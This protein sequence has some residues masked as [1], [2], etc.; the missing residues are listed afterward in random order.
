M[1]S[2]KSKITLSI[3]ICSLLSSLL[4]GL[5]SMSNVRQVSNKGASSEMSLSAENTKMQIDALITRIEQSVDTLSSIFLEQVDLEQMQ[6]SD[7]YVTAL[8][9]S[10]QSI[11]LSF[12]QHTEGTITA[13]IRYNP[14]FTDP[15]SGL[16]LSRNSLSED[17]ISIVPTDFTMYE[18]T[19]LAHVGCYYIPVEN[20]APLWMDPYLN[21][22]INVYMVSYVVPIYIDGVSVG[23]IGM[24]IDFS[25]ICDI[26]D[27]VTVFDSGY[28]FLTSDDGVITHHP[29]LETGTDLSEAYGGIP[30]MKTALAD[31]GKEGEYLEYSCQG[32][33]R[34]FVYYSLENGMKLVV[35]ASLSEIKADADKLSL[36]ILYFIIFSIILS[37]VLGLVISSN[38]ANPLKKMTNII[39]KTSELDFTSSGSVGA[40]LVKRRDETGVMAKAVQAMRKALRELVQD[41]MQTESSIMKNVDR[42]SEI[43]EQNRTISEDNSATTQEMAAGMQET[44]SNTEVIAEDIGGIR[45]NAEDIRTMTHQG[46]TASQEVAARARA[47]NATVTSSSDKALKM[48]DLMKTKTKEAMKQSEAV[49]RINEMTDIIKSISSQTNLLALNA[50]IEA[51]RAGDA[52]RGFAVVATEIGSLASQTLETVNGINSIVEEVNLAVNSMKECMETMMDYMNQTVVT[53]YASFRDVS[54]KY[55]A[56]AKEFMDDMNQ[57][58]S[59][60]TELYSKIQDITKTIN[61]VNATVEQSAEGVGLIAEKSVEAVKKTQE[62]HMHL[63]DSKH[64][65]DQLQQLVDRFRI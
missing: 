24:D 1:R 28:V 46:Q 48:F 18:K 22:N 12:G 3:I 51:A 62:G 37:V 14:D 19:D 33:E 39:I 35:N 23:I 25:Q 17:F 13:Y 64:S 4:I 31:T 53:D 11:T 57:I 26:V 55:E 42:L 36:Q 15:T 56:D 27:E 63:E 43:M 40:R 60:I 45:K 16:F 59:E 7:S 20:K 32:E 21:S 41:M 29:E 2:I 58:Y 30:E 8:T 52:G 65:I 5:A 38:I 6:T 9:E 44:R 61:Q 54:V 47:L 34:A 10:F 50:N 49:A